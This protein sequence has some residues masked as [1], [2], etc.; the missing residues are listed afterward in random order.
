MTFSGAVPEIPA[1]RVVKNPEFCGKKVWDPV[2]V[3]NPSNRGIKNTVVYLEEVNR[4]KPFP[5]RPF[6]DAFKCLFVPHAT[7]VF[8][9]KPVLLHNS[10]TIFHNIHAFNEQGK[11]IFNFALPT[12]SEAVIETI[13]KSGVIRIQCDSHLHMN[14]WAVSL[15]HPYFSVTDEMGR[16]RITDVPPG[17]YTLVA[18]HEGYVMTNRSAYEASLKSSQGHLE[19]PVYDGAWKITNPVK[20]N[21]DSDIK[22]NLVF[23]HE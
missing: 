8:E 3:V 15:S 21:A 16:F 9:G 2:L 19:R 22:M 5:H 17:N 6:I 13:K 7:V 23:N 4:G 14:G 10:D 11:T 1:I 20:V 18:W 12:L